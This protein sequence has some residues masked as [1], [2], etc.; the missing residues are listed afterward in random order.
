MTF[1]RTKN[2]HMLISGKMNKPAL[3]NLCTTF[4]LKCTGNKL[5]LLNRL[6]DYSCQRDLWGQWVVPVSLFIFSSFIS[7]RLKGAS[8]RPHRGPSGK[9]KQTAPKKKSALRRE[10][11]FVRAETGTTHTVPLVAVQR[12]TDS[13]RAETSEWVR[14]LLCFHTN[15]RAQSFFLGWLHQWKVPL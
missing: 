3:A 15:L 4:G 5:D 11:L 7:F 9:K 8:R 13:R 2:I 12:Q 10:M 6:R 14:T 1:I